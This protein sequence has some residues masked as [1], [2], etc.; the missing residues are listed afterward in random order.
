MGFSEVIRDYYDTM[1][2]DERD[3][4]V[5]RLLRSVD[6]LRR[7]V[8]NMLELS[9]LESGQFS[10][11]PEHFDLKDLLDE[12]TEELKPRSIPCELEMEVSGDSGTVYADRDKIEIVLFNLID[13]AIK[14][15][16]PGSRITVSS[17][18]YPDRAVLEVSDQGRGISSE[19]VDA[20]F[21]PFE[22]G[23]EAKRVSA[24]GMGLGLYIVKKLV[25]AHDGHIEL[26]TG[27]GEGST[28]T[29]TIPQ[30]GMAH[31]SD[32]GSREALRA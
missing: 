15:S 6:R 2:R 11:Q 30:D 24:Q 3:Q 28:F 19:Y 1:Q 5:D 9:R 7:S 13:N 14:F 23:E 21:E 25:E 16:Q 18:R 20:V 4:V 12:L 22:R 32:P 31:V 26:R 17:R 10:I 8:I 27:Q 29:I